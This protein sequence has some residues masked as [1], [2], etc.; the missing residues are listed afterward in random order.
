[1]TI[2]SIKAGSELFGTVSG[3]ALGTGFAASTAAYFAGEVPPGTRA[4]NPSTKLISALAWSMALV[5][6]FWTMIATSHAYSGAG[7]WQGL[8]GWKWD[9]RFAAVIAYTFGIFFAFDTF[10]GRGFGPL[11]SS[12]CMAVYILLGLFMLVN[13]LSAI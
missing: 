1:M 4:D 6:G 2:W 13:L 5:A 11:S 3:F 12:A 9:Y 10:R 7:D 8:E